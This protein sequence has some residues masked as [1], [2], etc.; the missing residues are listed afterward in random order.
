MCPRKLT[1][2][3]RNSAR[4]YGVVGDR[5]VSWRPA[6][7]TRKL[8]FTSPNNIPSSKGRAILRI[9]F[10]PGFQTL[11]ICAAHDLHRDHTADV[12]S[13]SD[14]RDELAREA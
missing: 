10:S 2:A 6:T 14:V 4:A 9:E 12:T 3:A 11:H 5:S 1:R 7:V 13:K 8:F